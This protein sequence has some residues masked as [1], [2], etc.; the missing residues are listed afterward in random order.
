VANYGNYCTREDLKRAANWWGT[1]KHT[2]IDRL[3]DAASRAIEGA[4]RRWFFPRTQTRLYRWPDFTQP[5]SV[6]LWL[7]ADLLSVSLLQAKAQ[8]AT[9]TTIVAADYFKEPVNFGPPYDR[10]EIDLSSSS[11][12]DTGA[13]PQRS[14]S[15]AG[16]WGYSE[17][18]RMG[19]TVTSG[20]AADA[21]AVSMVCSNASLIGVGDVLL[22][23]SEQVFVSERDFAILGTVQLNDT[24]TADVADVTVT[25]D[26]SHGI[27]AGEV[28]L[29]GSEEML[30]LSVSTNDLTVQRAYNGTVLASH[31]SDT[32]AYLARTLTIVRGVNGTTAAVHANSTAISVYAVLPDIKTWCIAEAIS[33]YNQEGAGWG[34]VVGSGDGAVEMS[35][36]QL[37]E[38][39]RSMTAQY[40]R[41]RSAA[42]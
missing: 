1:D 27:L 32:P 20:L 4:T 30:V 33:L 36:R 9:P 6:I 8:D 40:Q 23:G 19:G 34:R 38:M 7:D 25:M 41:V 14:I 18:T 37:A 12:F 24:L 2:Q 13:T 16:S 35:G 21:A 5:S 42:I 26:A 11:A 28:L 22:I 39:R 17:A 3:A 10:I 29:L 31:A 15:V